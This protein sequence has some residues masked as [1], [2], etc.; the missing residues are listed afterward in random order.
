VQDDESI[1][2]HYTVG[3]LL[4]GDYEVAFTCDGENF[5]PPEG[6]PATIV[7]GELET[8]DFLKDPEPAP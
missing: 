2:Y 6:K 5:E 3:F 1:E 7:A 4:A 8:V